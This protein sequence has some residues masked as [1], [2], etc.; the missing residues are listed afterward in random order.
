MTTKTKIETNI[1]DDAADKAMQIGVGIMSVAAL[2]GLVDLHSYHDRKN[3]IMP[4]HPVYA[5]AGQN[6]EDSSNTLRRERDEAGPHYVS[7]SAYQ[8]TP[9]RS[10][11]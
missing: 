10:K 2:A 6:N 5:F 4:M 1:F 3:A 11:Q 7:Y 8:R 9:G